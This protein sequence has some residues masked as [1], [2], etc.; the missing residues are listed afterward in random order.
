MTAFH[1]FIF[2][3]DLFQNAQRTEK[4]GISGELIELGAEGARRKPNLSGKWTEYGAQF[5]AAYE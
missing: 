3:D 1:N 2:S 4:A 5:G